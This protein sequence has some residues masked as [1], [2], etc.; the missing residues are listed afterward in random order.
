MATNRHEFPATVRSSLAHRAG[1]SCANPEC[2]APTAGPSEE[3]ELARSD[4]GVASHITAAAPGGPRYEASLSESDRT[5][6]DNGVWLCQVCAKKIDDDVVRYPS[7]VLRRWKHEVEADASHR[8][9][10]PSAATIGQARARDPLERMIAHRMRD[11]LA[12]AT[13]PIAMLLPRSVGNDAAYPLSQLLNSPPAAAAGFEFVES[14]VVG[15][16][17]DALAT[18]KLLEPAAVPFAPD[19]IRW[20][21]WILM[22]FSACTGECEQAVTLYASRGP[23]VLVAQFEQL[24]RHMK[25][26]TGVLSA[27]V[28]QQPEELISETGRSYFVHTLKVLMKAQRTWL[29]F[30][31]AWQH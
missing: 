11:A 26:T 16:I 19:S 13:F 22:G 3:S 15:P 28:R 29:D 25:V 7:D 5:S 18:R 24:V 23:S 30:L 1:F 12:A 8:L 10:R 17:V 27:L 6:I 31:T 9:G 2:R 20:I 21:D 14:S 4:V